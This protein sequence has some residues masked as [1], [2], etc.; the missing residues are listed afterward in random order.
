M[1]RVECTCSLLR[2]HFPAAVEILQLRELTTWKTG[3][4]AV[5]VAAT[6]SGML[7]DLLGLTFKE[8]IPWFILGRGSNVLAS[9]SG[10]KEVIIR[11][12]GN[13]AE[14]AW[15]RSENGWNLM[16]G[17][18]VHLPSLSGAACNRGASGLEFAIGIPG[19]I[20]GA[21]FMNAG[22]YGNSISDFLSRVSVLDYRGST[23]IIAGDECCFGY[24]FSRFQKERTVI[25]G[26]ELSLGNDNPA[27]LRSEGKRILSLRRKKF[28]LLYPNAGSVFRKPDEGIPP[29]KLIEDAGLKGRSVGGARVSR[30]H[31]NFIIN[32]GKATSDDIAELIDI[33]RESVL[34]FSGILL[35]EEIRY[36]GRR[37]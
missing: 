2:D 16:T 25:T 23:N 33:V 34:A 4:P 17:G 29:G 5:S 8:G 24:R 10:C 19:T 30:K 6:S 3:G 7:E 9:D 21:V 32:T 27:V 37:N 13:M 28:P 1:N 36:L 15:H 14:T 20:G 18:G 11:L 22:A 35:K 12:S 26:I 31:A